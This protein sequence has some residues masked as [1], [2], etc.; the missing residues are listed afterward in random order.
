MS[1][2]DREVDGP[3]VRLETYRTALLQNG[4]VGSVKSFPQARDPVVVMATG[5]EVVGLVVIVFVVPQQVGVKVAV[6]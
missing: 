1:H 6:A 3:V 2:L 4:L 5:R